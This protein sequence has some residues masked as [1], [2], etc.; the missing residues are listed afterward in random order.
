M[1]AKPLML[2][3]FLEGREVPVISAVCTGGVNTGGS[4][5]VQVVPADGIMDFLPRTLVHLF[6]YDG[7]EQAEDVRSRY[8]LL[9]VGEIMGVEYV[10]STSQR[11]AVLKCLDFSSYWDAA[12][13]LFYRTFTSDTQQPKPGNTTQMMVASGAGAYRYDRTKQS[14]SSM[15]VKVLTSKSI[16]HPDVEGFMG[17]LL[18]MLEMLG[19]IYDGSNTENHRGLNDFFSQSELRLHLSR[20]LGAARKDTS[21]AKLLNSRHFRKWIRNAISQQGHTISFRTVLDLVLKRLSSYY[22]SQLCPNYTTKEIVEVV[23]TVTKAQKKSIGQRISDRMAA[24]GRLKKEVDKALEWADKDYGAQ[25]TQLSSTFDYSLVAYSEEGV[26]SQEYQDPMQGLVRTHTSLGAELEVFAFG[27]TDS[28]FNTTDDNGE[29]VSYAWGDPGQLLKDKD[30][31]A[32]AGTDYNAVSLAAEMATKQCVP[33]DP[34]GQRYPAITVT[35]L[36]ALKVKLDGAHKAYGKRATRYTKEKVRVKE[37]KL[38]KLYTHTFTPDQFLCPAPR[39]NVLFPEHISSMSMSRNFMQEITRLHLTTRKE[40]EGKGVRPR[41]SRKTFVAPHVDVLF[42]KS[43]AKMMRNVEYFI[44]PHEVYAGIIPRFDQVPDMAAYE[45]L[46]K[47]KL[48]GAPADMARVDYLVRMADFLFVKYRIAGRIISANG[49]FNPTV[50]AGMAML[51]LPKPPG[52][53]MAEKLDK[54]YD[55]QDWRALT[56]L[57]PEKYLAQLGENI[58]KNLKSIDL[59]IQYAGVL[60]SLQHSISQEGGTSNYTISHVWIPSREEIPGISSMD[61]KYRTGYKTV[62]TVKRVHLTGVVLKDTEQ[63]SPEIHHLSVDA[64]GTQQQIL[65]TKSLDDWLAYGTKDTAEYLANTTS[66]S[67][68]AGQVQV[69]VDQLKT[70]WIGPNGGYLVDATFKG[71]DTFT[72]KPEQDPKTGERYS[73]ATS[74]TAQLELTEKVAIY[75]HKALTMPFEYAVRPVWLAEVFSNL[76]IGQH[77]YQDILGCSSICDGEESKVDPKTGVPQSGLGIKLLASAVDRL[78]TTAVI[79]LERDGELLKPDDV[80]N[81]MRLALQ[82]IIG[83]STIM[84][85]AASVARL[86]LKYQQFGHSG[87][88]NQFI[89]QYTRRGFASMNDILG[90]GDLLFDLATGVKVSGEEGFHSRAYGPWS[91]YVLLDHPKL[92]MYGSAG[93]LRKLDPK[94]DPREARHDRIVAYLQELSQYGKFST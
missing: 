19:G 7:D 14:P 83:G 30:F 12:R 54:V 25:A 90:T 86:Y 53:D 9:F 92:R 28:G 89:T 17:G 46:S 49:R 31:S 50:A 58:G 40:W 61:V 16:R 45:K 8:K 74:G 43:A 93:E 48:A 63:S 80:P 22:S 69:K 24:V 51:V 2:R 18:L 68:K 91:Q 71:W 38:P 81:K 64:D 72:A 42:G 5:S 55:Q 1:E 33:D 75:A 73:V 6:F 59:P 56:T 35:K 78:I 94:I 34:I 39:C 41:Y 27:S 77:F 79:Q 13:L 26:T 65:E 87:A 11:A 66:K 36:Q 15:L 44:F 32:P 10:R 3:L 67:A 82:D 76:R 88:L 57:D 60:H 23:H 52:P 29:S 20:T 62:K 85:S 70:K 47:E 4:A 84:Q 37:T 21:S